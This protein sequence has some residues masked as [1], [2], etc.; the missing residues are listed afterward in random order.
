[1]SEDQ[2][3]RDQLLV[4]RAQADAEAFEALVKRWHAVLW[5]HAYR[6]TRNRETAWDVMQEAWCAIFRGI[7]RLDDAGAFPKWAFRIV[8]NKCRDTA[9]SAGRRNAAM[10]TYEEQTN[11]SVMPHT[12]DERLELALAQLDPELRMLVGLYYEDSFGVREISE[13]TGWPEGSVKSRLHR[14]RR[15]LRHKMEEMDHD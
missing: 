7:S 1:M 10:S 6:L 11:A 3:I 5:R 13:I 9:R 15:E 2:Q 8:T 12:A 14:A 4:L